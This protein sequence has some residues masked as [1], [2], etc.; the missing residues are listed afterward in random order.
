[1]PSTSRVAT[2]PGPPGTMSS[3]GQ[4]HMLGVDHLGRDLLTRVLY[5]AR[6]SLTIA[7]IVV[8]FQETF[9]VTLGALSGF[10]GGW[11]DSRDLAHR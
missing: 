1:M 10:Y 11:P 7:F 8:I 9:G 6:V 5:G 2:R 3:T 4:V